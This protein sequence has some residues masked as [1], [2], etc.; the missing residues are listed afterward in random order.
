[1]TSKED[2]QISAQAQQALVKLL[3]KEGLLPAAVAGAAYSVTDQCPISF[4]G[5]NRHLD[6]WVTIHHIGRK[7]SF[8]I[9]EVDRALSVQLLQLLEDPRLKRLPLERWRSLR[10]LP[11]EISEK[12]L[13]VGFAN[14]LA[15][16]LK[17]QLEFE[18]G[19]SIR[20]AIAHEGQI[21][22]VLGK[23]VNATD[24]FDVKNIVAEGA[25]AKIERI[26]D[27]LSIRDASVYTGDLD[28][29]PVVRLVNKTLFE[30]IEKGASDVHLTPEKEKLSIRIRVDGVMQPLFDI[31]REMQPAVVSRVKL[32]CGMNIA[33][34][35]KPQDGR[36]R[37]KTPLGAKDIRVSTVPSM[38]GE[39]VVLRILSAEVAAL[40]LS[41]LGISPAVEPRFREL[42]R[43]SSRV[44]LV[45]GPTG[46]GKTS[47]LYAGLLGVR[48]GSTHIITVE[49]PV[50]YR[51]DGVTQIPV[52]EKTGMTFASGLRSILR[53]DPDVVM[54]GEIRDT[55]TAEI[56]FQAAQT[57]HLVL[58]TVHT[59][60]AEA[61]ITRFRDLKIP[62][63]VIAS[64]LGGVLAQ[65]L[66]RRL[67]PSCAVSAPVETHV[68]LAERGITPA[69]ARVPKGCEECNH[70]GFKG[71]TGIYS[72][73][74]ITNDVREAIRLDRG[75]EEIVRLARLHGYSP[76]DESA[77]AVVASGTSSLDEVES[78]VGSLRLAVQGHEAAPEH[79]TP[80]LQE[81]SERG[82]AGLTKPRVLLI[83]DDENTRVVLSMVLKRAFYDVIE[84]SDG[85]VAL[86]RLCEGLP[87][88][89]ICDYMM[90]E[91]S[92]LDVLRKIRHDTHTRTL[93]FL[94][95]TAADQAEN[96]VKIMEGGADDF[97]SKAAD[98]KVLLARVQRLLDRRA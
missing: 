41:A 53:Q 72:L 16:D 70:T 43:G 46:S 65:R 92:G 34:R 82:A 25:P 57:G 66:V 47:T 33:E 76:L 10:A 74:E 18:L 98:T 84:A 79:P 14:P 39:N 78:V 85:V 24:L 32:L 37:V 4:F 38:Y 17:T 73:L 3:V 42:L 83:E 27:D 55:E 36:M 90:P 31:P 7:L 60:S 86:E 81:R 15:H 63:Y 93:P 89:V 68:A 87:D 40:S 48:D 8:P 88:M 29:A 12:H 54:V 28:A 56:A 6:E 94:M 9:V 26:T 13:V 20:V 11:I 59:N 77:R 44:V 21:L 96:E 58:S 22:A 97:V 50:E 95:L 23:G 1:M 62:S 49:D 2:I 75:E 64:S 80:G 52:N 5:A 30:S 71:R 51:V 69:E 67:C 91:M 61:T 19:L 45:T 35:R